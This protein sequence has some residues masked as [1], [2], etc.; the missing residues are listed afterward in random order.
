M[1]YKNG[2]Q[3]IEPSVIQ[4]TERRLNVDSDIGTF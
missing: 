1:L 4:L 3:E 2:A